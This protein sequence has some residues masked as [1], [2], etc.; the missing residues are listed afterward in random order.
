MKL[1]LDFAL[2]VIREADR[3]YYAGAVGMIRS[4]MRSDFSPFAKIRDIKTILIALD[5]V[6]AEN[7]R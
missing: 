1:E 2:S 3:N 5:T 6:L 7:S 4:I